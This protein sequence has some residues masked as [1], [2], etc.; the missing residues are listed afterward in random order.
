MG[1]RL[2]S[3]CKEAQVVLQWPWMGLILYTFS[4]QKTQM[5]IHARI[6][7]FSWN[8]TKTTIT[9][10]KNYCNRNVRIC[11]LA[12][13]PAPS[14]YWLFLN[15]VHGKHVLILSVS[16]AHYIIMT[17]ERAVIVGYR[18]AAY[19]A[20]YNTYVYRRFAEGLLAPRQQNRTD[21][22]CRSP[23]AHHVLLLP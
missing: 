16:F 12:H 3:Y 4:T 5:L 11:R 15:R 6:S 18:V 13:R 14:K 22:L 21:P 9:T 19:K 1:S 8:E 17:K 2:S 20:Y 10:E 7:I 23:R